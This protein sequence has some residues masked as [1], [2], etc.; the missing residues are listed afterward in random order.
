MRNC[1]VLLILIIAIM[2]QAGCDILSEPLFTEIFIEAENGRTLRQFFQQ[3]HI[4]DEQEVDKVDTGYVAN[5]YYKKYYVDGQLSYLGHN[6]NPSSRTNYFTFYPAGPLESMNVVCNT[7]EYKKIEFNQDGT[8]KDKQKLFDLHYKD[9]MK[10]GSSI[11]V[12]YQFESFREVTMLF[13]IKV[14][15]LNNVILDTSY[16]EPSPGNAV[17]L[18]TSSIIFPRPGIYTYIVTVSLLDSASQT[19]LTKESKDIKLHVH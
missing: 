2:T 13:A 7:G 18:L 3:G 14:W 10:A 19:F 12:L 6:R 1:P 5:G 4:I 15:H 8:R 9:S 16:Q 11:P 17:N